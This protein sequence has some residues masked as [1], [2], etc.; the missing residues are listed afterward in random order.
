MYLLTYT[1][2][3][4]A[5]SWSVPGVKPQINSEMEVRSTRNYARKQIT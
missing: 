2:K 1:V 3:L 4:R 5:M